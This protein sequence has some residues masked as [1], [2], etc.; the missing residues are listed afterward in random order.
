MLTYMVI[1]YLAGRHIRSLGRKL[2]QSEHPETKQ[3][4]K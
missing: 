4:H 3:L 2:G 1:G